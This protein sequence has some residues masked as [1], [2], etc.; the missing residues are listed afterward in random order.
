VFWNNTGCWHSKQDTINGAFWNGS[1][2]Y[3][4]QDTLNGVFYNGSSWKS[5]QDS[6]NG[7]F[8]NTTTGLSYG[9]PQPSNSST[10]RPSS[11]T[12]RI[13]INSTTGR[14][15]WTIN[16]TTQTNSGTN[17]SNGTKT[18]AL[19]GLTTNTAYRVWVNA[20]DNLSSLNR[21]FTFTTGA[22][23][24]GGGFDVDVDGATVTITPTV[25]D[26]TTEYKFQFINDEN[27]ETAWMD[28]DDLHK[29]LFMMKEGGWLEI[30]MWVTNGTANLSY[31][32]TIGVPGNTEP[33]SDPPDRTPTGPYP[34]FFNVFAEPGKRIQEFF[35]NTPPEYLFI[36]AVA[37]IIITLSLLYYKPRKIIYYPVK[38]RRRK[39]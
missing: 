22:G 38:N 12:W 20:T 23:A 27:G 29:Y 11:F 19:T 3:S 2:W 17:D 26:N 25:N 35:S 39:K 18:L 4:V 30:I 5:Q 15:N 14:F 32:Q 16:C 28:A 6:I 36:I 10:G 8:Y 1:S 9:T 24:P 37:I 13:P 31:R 33:Y 21:W 34:K 7:S